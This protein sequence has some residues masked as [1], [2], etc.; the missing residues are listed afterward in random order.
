[1]FY[2]LEQ[3][4]NFMRE[5]AEVL[6]DQGLWVLEQSYMPTMLR[7]NSYDT[8]CHEHLEYYALKQ[9]RW[10]ANKLGLRI[11]DVEFNDINGGS[12]SLMV[13]KQKSRHVE[14]PQ[15]AQIL[16]AEARG[17][18]DTLRPYQEFAERVV[19]SRAGLRAFLD[20]A[21][22]FNKSV[23]ALGASTKGNVLLQYCN[24]TE[25]DISRVGEVNP[26]KFEAFT[27]GTLLPIVSEDEMLASKPDYLL[28]LPWHF[29]DFFVEQPRFAG[30]NLIFP[31]PELEFVRST[32][33]SRPAGDAHRL[34]P[35]L[36]RHTLGPHAWLRH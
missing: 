14:S 1:M 31:L 9:I 8:V 19:A 3:P 30:R 22:R 15:V 33:P 2:D 26:D 20:D 28:A 6:D 36:V 11:V 23:A 16:D 10:M 32:E 29:R 13:A 21:K 35:E 18:L 12:F 17:G 25:A 7:K 24:V 34:D 27:P 4:M 5:V